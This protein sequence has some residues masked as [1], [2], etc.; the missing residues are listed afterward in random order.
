MNIWRDHYCLEN[1][2]D[3][4][5]KLSINFLVCLHQYGGNVFVEIQ[6]GDETQDGRTKM[7]E[8]NMAAMRELKQIRLSWSLQ[9]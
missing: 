4:K 9:D 7:A 5:T 3:S 2:Y 8:F 6:D 1:D